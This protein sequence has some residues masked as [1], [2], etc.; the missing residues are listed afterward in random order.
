[1]FGCI[2][3]GKAYDENKLLYEQEYLCA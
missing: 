3:G 2:C 1:M